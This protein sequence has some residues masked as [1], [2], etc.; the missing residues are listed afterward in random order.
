M[1]RY[2]E[3]H[4]ELVAFTLVARSLGQDFSTPGTGWTATKLSLAS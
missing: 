2:V 1:R 4:F 3:R